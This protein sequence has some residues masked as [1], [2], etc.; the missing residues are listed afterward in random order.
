MITFSDQQSFL[1]LVSPPAGYKLTYCLGTAFSLD[2]DCVVAMAR[3]TAKNGR[4]EDSSELNIYEALQGIAEFTQNSVVFVQACQI[5]ALERQ[6]AALHA[7]DYGRLISLLDQMVVP[8]SAPGIKSSFHPKVWL[9]KFDVD[10]GTGESIYRLLVAS[11]NLC[12]QMDWEI[13]CVLEGRRETKSNDLSRRLQGFFS[14]LKVSVPKSKQQLFQKVLTD[15]RTIGFQKPPRTRSAQFL[16][17]DSRNQKGCWIDPSD[18]VGLIVISPAKP[19]GSG[20][21]ILQI[22]QIHGLQ[23]SRGQALLS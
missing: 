11:R 3:V 22:F 7:K 18:Y 14:S 4:S 5:K 8:V 13:G 21:P 19:T 2:L 12:K 23:T 9:V 10:H 16:F 1:Q 6:Q 17:K 15:L 20:F